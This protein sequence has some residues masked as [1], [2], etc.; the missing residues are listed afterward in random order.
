M[1]YIVV[2]TILILGASTLK[3]AAQKPSIELLP[4]AHK[5]ESLQSMID[6]CVSPDSLFN[7]DTI[8]PLPEAKKEEYSPALRRRSMKTPEMLRPGF[9]PLFIKSPNPIYFIIHFT[10]LK[11]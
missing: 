3:T 2:Y 4:S 5:S 11:F 8:A 10:A 9:L 6:T 7:F 1:R